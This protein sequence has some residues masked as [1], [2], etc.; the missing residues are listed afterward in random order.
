M[1]RNNIGVAVGLSASVFLLFA[2]CATSPYALS[3][4]AAKDIFVH[5][6]D[7]QRLVPFPM[8]SLSVVSSLHE[9]F[10]GV[11]GADK[12]SQETFAGYQKLQRNGLITIANM[13]DLTNGFQGWNAWFAV[14]Q[15]GIVK[16]FSAEPTTK[17]KDLACPEEILKS[18][19]L[20]KALCISLGK[21]VSAAVTQNQLLTSGSD[22]FR[23]VRGLYQWS[24]NPLF[25]TVME[26]HEGEFKSER[27]FALLLKFDPFKKSWSLAGLDV[28]NRDEEFPDKI[29]EKNTAN[30]TPV[31]P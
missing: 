25:V 5:L 24:W 30:M 4:R 3:D 26:K 2:A 21:L 8:G 22:Y 28:A 15:Q 29:V 1:D 14:S 10:E 31:R 27:K 20:R 23:V 13:R 9:H 19:S 17:A 12:I 6:F 7:G 18:S 16:Q 11:K